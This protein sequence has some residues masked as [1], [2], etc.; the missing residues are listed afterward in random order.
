MRSKKHNG[1]VLLSTS[2]LKSLPVGRRILRLTDPSAT[3]TNKYCGRI[4]EDKACLGA[5][6]G[7]QAEGA[8]AGTDRLHRVSTSRANSSSRIDTAITAGRS[9]NAAEKQRRT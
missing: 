7:E 3:N 1:T 6:A 8:Q 4:Q 9:F 2:I 5:T